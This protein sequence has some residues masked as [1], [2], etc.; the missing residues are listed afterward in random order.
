MGGQQ[1]D[2]DGSRPTPAAVRVPGNDGCG[3]V[4]VVEV[5][6]GEKGDQRRVRG[7]VEVTTHQ[8]RQQFLGV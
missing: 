3:H 6:G 4:G 5:R 7:A 2:R 8:D 1:G